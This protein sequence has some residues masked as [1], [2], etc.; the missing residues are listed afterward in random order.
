M[1]DVGHFIVDE[2]SIVKELNPDL[3]FFLFHD[4]MGNI[5]VYDLFHMNASFYSTPQP[6]NVLPGNYYKFVAHAVSYHPALPPISLISKRKK[7]LSIIVIV[8]NDV[9]YIE[10]TL[11]SIVNQDNYCYELIVIDGGSSDGTIEKLNKY[12]FAID[13]L[14]VGEDTGIYNAMNIGIER[15]SSEW[16]IFLNAGDFF[17]S[18]SSLDVDFKQFD[19]YDA[20]AFH[21]L[22][23]GERLYWMR[24]LHTDFRLYQYSHQSILFRRKSDVWY[25]ETLSFSADQDFMSKYKDVLYYSKCISVF[26]LGGISTSGFSMPQIIERYMQFGPKSAL[27]LFVRMFLQKIFS[28][29]IFE[30]VWYGKSLMSQYL[31]RR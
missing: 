6:L 3:M 13:V 22:N 5:D 18:K 9:F 2:M 19:G 26:R 10:Q 27:I 25:D 24:P 7:S 30:I 8:K 4:N 31:S 20:I 23:R 15:S 16:M 12:K 14:V 11:Q 1:S 21:A 17:F 28:K 29:H